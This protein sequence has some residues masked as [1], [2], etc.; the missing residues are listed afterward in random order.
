VD[1]EVTIGP[2]PDPT[3]VP[4]IAFS[5][6]ACPEWSP[7]EVVDRAAALGY[8]AVE[9]RGG[10]EGHVSTAWGDDRRAA[11][12]RRMDERGLAALAVT[13]YS[14]FTSPDTADREANREHLRA[15]I[16]LARDLGAPFVRTFLGFRI[17]DAGDDAMTA[18]LA[19]AIAAVADEAVTLGVTI[20]IEPHD[21]FVDAPSVAA[22]LRALDHP[23]VGAIWDIGNAWEAGER[24]ETGAAA[25]APW[26]RYI[27]VKDGRGR[28]AGWQL[29]RL[30][31]GDVP[32]EAALTLVASNGPLPPISLE[33][34]RAWH[35]ELDP[36]DT[37]LG[38][39][40]RVIRSL[41]TEA[42]RASR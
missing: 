7:E 25:L 3:G 21:D 39:S 28:G 13:A 31:E 22:V 18:R 2:V 30:G 34:E 29:T 27:Q 1:G 19:G 9:W 6:L 15:H 5:T 8:D 38:P 26:I 40:L 32:L 37:V 33:W 35:P 17:D 24:P 41:A 10:D 42:I 36:A 20:V 11:L 23:A 14:V 12:R 4:P 16:R